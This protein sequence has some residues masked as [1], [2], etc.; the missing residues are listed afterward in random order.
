MT[1]I[2]PIDDERDEA[3]RALSAMTTLAAQNL[4]AVVDE[5]LQNG[6]RLDAEAVAALVTRLDDLRGMYGDAWTA[7]GAM[8]GA[9]RR[10]IE[11]L[12]QLAEPERIEGDI[13]GLVWEI[14]PGRE[15][16]E[17]LDDIV[18]RP[19]TIGERL[20]TRLMRYILWRVTSVDDPRRAAR[21]LRHVLAAAFDRELSALIARGGIMAPSLARGRDL[22]ALRQSLSS[23]LKEEERHAGRSESE[24]AD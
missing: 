2:D 15:D 13:A 18:A 12:R 6:K 19:M 7:A 17:D 22:D 24:R 14:D 4:Q 9:L 23:Y 11:Y 20:A 21:G 5:L 16:R 3:Q 1:R 10:D 8:I